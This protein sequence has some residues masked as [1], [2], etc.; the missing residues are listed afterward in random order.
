[1]DGAFQFGGLSKS[2]LASKHMSFSVDDIFIFQGP[3]I[4]LRTQL[5]G[6]FT[7]YI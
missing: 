6:K 3:K 2:N 7:P 4:R 5:K 1:V